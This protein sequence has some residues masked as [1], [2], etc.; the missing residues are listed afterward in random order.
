MKKTSNS[1]NETYRRQAEICKAFANPTRLQLIDLLRQGERWASE[2]QEGLGISKANLSQHL[3]ILRAAGVVLTQ[4]E[5]KQLYC[6]ISMPEVKQATA[7]LR[8]MSKRG[9]RRQAL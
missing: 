2:L 6:G 7:I 9:S 3:S 4:R 1:G 5:G 8:S